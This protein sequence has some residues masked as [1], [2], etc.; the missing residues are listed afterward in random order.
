MVSEGDLDARQLRPGEGNALICFVG[1][2]VISNALESPKIVEAIEGLTPFPSMH[3]KMDDGHIER[4]LDRPRRAG[5]PD[6]SR[7]GSLF[8]KRREG[9]CSQAESRVH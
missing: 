9:S 4:I 7:V 2:D 3:P 5:E 1:S 6:W 8:S